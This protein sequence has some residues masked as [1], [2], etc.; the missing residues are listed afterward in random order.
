MRGTEWGGGG[1][2]GV[3]EGN[4]PQFNSSTPCSGLTTLALSATTVVCDVGCHLP[5]QWD[6]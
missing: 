6:V 5:A 1:G 2:G 3:G 4:F